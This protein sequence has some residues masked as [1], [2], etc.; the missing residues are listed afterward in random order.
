MT[1][2]TKKENN[3]DEAERLFHDDWASKIDVNL[4]DPTISFESKV[5]L[6]GRWIFE[7]IGNVKGLK[8]LELGSGAGEGAVYFAMK[9]ANVT[10]TDLSP[11][12][13]KVAVKLAKKIMYL[14]KHL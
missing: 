11:G 6:E 9:G 7:K 14:L 4:I 2:K 12:M 8:L 10:A 13:L 1:P 5:A 3:V